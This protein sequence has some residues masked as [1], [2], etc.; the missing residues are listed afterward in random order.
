MLRV[1]YSF[2]QLQMN[3]LENIFRER[4]RHLVDMFDMRCSI[5]YFDFFNGISS[6]KFLIWMPVSQQFRMLIR[7]VAD[8]KQQLL[9][10][11]VR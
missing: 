6:F 1:I 5:F 4:G 3:I 11:L 7:I 10:V 8:L 9:H 2:L